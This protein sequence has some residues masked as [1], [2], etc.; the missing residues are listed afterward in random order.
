MRIEFQAAT[1]VAILGSAALAAS[2]FAA[3]SELAWN[4]FVL[5]DAAVLTGLMGSLML[6]ASFI[7]RAV[8]VVVSGV[9]LEA[10]EHLKYSVSASGGTDSSA[11]RALASHRSGTQ[12]LAFLVSMALGFLAS[13]AGVSALGPLVSIS[14]PLPLFVRAVDILLTSLLLAGGAD[15]IHRAVSVALDLFDGTRKRIGVW[16]KGDAPP[17]AA[18][19]TGGAPIPRVVASPIAAAKPIVASTPPVSEP[20]S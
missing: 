9:R 1:A 10:A 11:I 2:R 12:Q 8:E 15:G 20:G 7:E 13:T 18:G 6:V 17:P 4:I 16:E 19:A 14:L 3:Q 5:P